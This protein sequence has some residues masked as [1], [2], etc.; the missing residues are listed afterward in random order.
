M[1]GQWLAA[2]AV[3]VLA[4]DEV[5]VGQ[6][7]IGRPLVLGPL[8]GAWF[9]QLELGTAQGAL[10]EMFTLEAVPV[11]ACAVP[12]AAIAAGAGLLLALGPEPVAPALA[13]PAGLA[14]GW[15]FQR[16]DARLRQARSGLTARVSSGGR[17]GK[18]VAGSLAVQAGVGAA[19]LALVLCARPLLAAAWSHSPALL[20]ESLGTALRLAPWLGGAILAQALWVR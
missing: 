17:F 15:A 3:S 10:T 2:A 4:L 7:M 6:F 20:Q 1:T 19:F 5:H 14:A 16:L 8:L 9:G 12:N 11:G 18:V 13:F